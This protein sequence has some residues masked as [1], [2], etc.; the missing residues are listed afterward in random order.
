MGGKVKFTG[1]T[2]YPF[3]DSAPSRITSFNIQISRE[4]LYWRD[5]YKD[6]LSIEPV[7][8]VFSEST[9]PFTQFLTMMMVTRTGIYNHLAGLSHL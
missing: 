7:C 4:G 6:P 3:R 8:M 9:T 5:V 1:I 2:I